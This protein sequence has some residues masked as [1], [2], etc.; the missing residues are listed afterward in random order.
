MVYS[1]YF[2]LFLTL[3]WGT[4]VFW[5]RNI[6]GANVVLLAMLLGVYHFLG[7]GFV[8]YAVGFVLFFEFFITVL[9][10]KDDIEVFFSKNFS[11]KAD[12]FKLSKTIRDF[13]EFAINEKIEGILV[14]KR[15]DSLEPFANT[16]EM[17][18]AKVKPFVLAQIFSQNSLLKTGAVIVE[19][20]EIV[21]VN[22]VLPKSKP[23]YLTSRERSALALSKIVDALILVFEKGK[24][25]L[26]LEG[27]RTA[28]N[29]QR[30]EAIFKT[31]N[32]S[33]KIRL[34]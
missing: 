32:L 26:F 24:I 9:I 8:F 33:K 10:Y 29:P 22:C 31:I 19:N 11:R 14:F 28:V 4:L 23:L 16:G 13:L 6:L 15:K 3:L 20:D 27:E 30:V 21:A 5:E 2:L 1:Y 7:M 34:S 17:L 25:T 18:R 12:Y